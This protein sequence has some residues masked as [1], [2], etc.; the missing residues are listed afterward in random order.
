MAEKEKKQGFNRSLSNAHIQL[1]ALGG[2]I[3]TGLFLGVGDSIQKSGTSVILTYIIV[4]AVLFLFM[5]ALGEL[6]LSDLHKHSYID[7]IEKYL[8]ERAS[9]VTGYLYWITYLTLAMTETIA[10]GMYFRYWWPKL[11][12]WLP[13]TV[14]IVLLLLIN[15]ISARFFG[16]LEFS[17]AIIK[18][19][20]I[21]GFVLLIGYM[22]LA[23][24]Q[25]KYG[26]V[27]FSKIIAPAGVFP[28]GAKGFLQGFQMVIFSFVGI[29]M[30][31]FTA[32][33][34][35]N[36]QKTMPKAI[37]E[38]PLRIIL[39]YV[40]AIIAL[41]LV[42]P[43]NQVSTSS[44]PFVQA[45]G[46]TGIKNTGSFINLVVISAGVSSCNTI[47]YSSGR[48]LFS[49]CFGR[50]GKFNKA[51][52]TLSRRQL[53]QNALLLSAGLIALAPLITFAI[54][55]RAF[56]FVSAT[57]TSMFLLIWLVMIVTHLIYR[58]TAHERSAFAMP[59]FP[60][61][62]YLIIAFFIAMIVLLIMMPSYRIPMTAA[63]VIFVVLY[64]VTGF[65]EKKAAGD[66]AQ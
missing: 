47:L 59:L 38:M 5:R 61:S 40:L 54:G 14:T 28:H 27:S 49:I 29:E 16:N 12:L 55:E 41:L 31:G 6:I 43:W 37:N 60:A 13:G 7:F 24:Q 19:A 9:L 21:I 42:I 64:F 36:P 32:S 20:T 45:L 66:T 56:S 63:L 35:K 4:G 33:E 26:A 58:K 17:F 25:T 1:I 8:G 18:I 50:K 48:L 39:F 15:L 10:L 52:S 57:T 3:G 46:A 2:T 51:M 62:D 44:S 65:I 53:P 23:H 30:I 34:A 11:P 22:L